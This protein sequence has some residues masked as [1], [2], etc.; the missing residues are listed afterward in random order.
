MADDLSKAP[1]RLLLDKDSAAKRATS[2]ANPTIAS[3]PP[4]VATATKEDRAD[5]ATLASRSLAAPVAKESELRRATGATSTPS[6]LYAD[7]GATLNYDSTVPAD[8]KIPA[9]A[10]VTSSSIQLR[11]SASKAEVPALKQ[12]FIQAQAFSATGGTLGLPRAQRQ[13]LAS[14]DLQQSEGALSIVDADG[15]VYTG[16]IQPAQA[17]TL[18]QRA[19]PARPAAD[20]SAAVSAPQNKPVVRNELAAAGAS[21]TTWF[22]RVTGTNNTSKQLLVFNGSLVVVSGASSTGDALGLAGGAGAKVKMAP[23]SSAIP[24]TNFQI[25]GKAQLGAAAEFEIKAS[26]SPR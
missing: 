5:S 18:A 9:P 3:E 10:A 19:R 7:R 6:A 25:T 15:S 16:F 20:S 23:Q 4:S 2:A 8:K 1:A 11:D 22:F 26:A 13:V 17:P 21:P 14:F 24:L 12:H